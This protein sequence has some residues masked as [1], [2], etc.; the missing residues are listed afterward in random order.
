MLRNDKLGIEP[1]NLNVPIGTVDI[2]QA[3]HRRVRAMNRRVPQGRLNFP[4]TQ[5]S[6]R[7]ADLLSASPAI[8]CWAIFKPSLTG[9]K[10]CQTR[11]L[12]S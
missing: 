10:Q 4:L 12:F 1:G 9:R 2:S 5:T 7:D 3:I 11:C 8:N 6:L